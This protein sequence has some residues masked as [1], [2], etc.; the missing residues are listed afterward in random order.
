MSPT[1]R[2]CVRIDPTHPSLPGHFPGQPLVP[3]VVL[4]QAV[5]DALR[6]WRG[7][8]LARIAEAKFMAP[9]LPGEEAELLLSESGARVR[10]ELRRGELLLARGAIEGEAA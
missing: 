9:L 2:T 6:A 10:F 4:L 7:Q 3:G 1:Y 5:A 8:R